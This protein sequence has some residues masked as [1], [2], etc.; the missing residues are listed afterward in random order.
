[1]THATL[2]PEQSWLAGLAT[3]LDT[4]HD[5]HPRIEGHVPAALRGTLYRNGPGRFDR[6]GMRKRHL[7]DGDGMIQAFDFTGNGVRY[8]N[9]YV[10]TA[11]F[12]EEEQAGRYTRPTWSTR[13]PGGPLRNA[14]NRIRSQA[15]VT[16]LLKNDRLYAFDEVG[17]PWGL[18]PGTLETLGEQSLGPAGLRAD[19]KAHTKTDPTTGDWAL[20][21]FQHGPRDH[22]HLV[23]HAANGVFKRHQCV[24]SPRGSYIHDWFLTER[25]AVILLHP[26]E[27]SLPGYLAG[28][29]S[30][31]ESLRW[32]A[33][34]GNLLMVIDR[35]GQTPVRTLEAPASFMWHS[36]NAY[37]QGTTIVADFVGYTAPDHFIGEHAAFRQ[38]MSGAMGEAR[39]PGLL[40]RYVIDLASGRVTED[41]L[42]DRNCEFPIVDPRAATRAHRYG[43]LTTAPGPT[44][45]HQGLARI[46]TSNGQV[47]LI[48][49]G[50]RTHLGEPIFVADQTAP[51]ERGWL[52]SIGLDGDSGTSFLGV[53]R[54]DA[55]ADG[56]IARLWLNHSTPLSF[57]GYWQPA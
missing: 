53:F 5:Y 31:T 8:R 38:I 29:R 23:E 48:D 18:D 35:S 25:Y 52:L 36:L 30:F 24:P 54:S 2:P 37:E 12:L 19:Y 27:L 45:F 55:L 39:H 49:L 26:I 4:E 22:I 10:R 7:L 40:R 28:L 50:P 56:P 34:Q 16:V 57:H 20:I 9:R 15:G 43:Y 17:Q 11:K 21:A 6:G 44:V 14:G 32:D 41:I 1:M 42:W 33:S 3:T 51:D 13:A 46:D 47:D